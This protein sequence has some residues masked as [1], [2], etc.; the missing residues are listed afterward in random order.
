MKPADSVDQFP[1][2]SSVG[3]VG[4]TVDQTPEQNLLYWSFSSLSWSSSFPEGKRVL[5]C[6]AM[7]EEP[8]D[9]QIRDEVNQF[10]IKQVALSGL[11][12]EA[13]AELL[14]LVL[15]VNKCEQTKG[16]ESNDEMSV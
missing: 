8:T 6:G 13:S 10:L 2:L 1:Q 16:S 3:I 9:E 4:G 14:R 15:L 5:E 7:S 12:M 11:S